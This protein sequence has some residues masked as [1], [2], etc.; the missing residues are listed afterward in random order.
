[1]GTAAEGHGAVDLGRG[2]EARVRALENLGVLDTGREERFDRLT[3]LARRL[4]GVASAAVT[5]IDRDRLYIKS[6]D[7]A[8]LLDGPR[9]EAF[10]DQTIR[11]PETLVV[12]DMRTD[13]R[14]ADNPLVTGDPHVRFYAGH[15]LTAPGGHRVGA[16]CLIDDRPRTFTPEER[17]LLEELADWAQQELTRSAELEQAA[18]V[19]R[20][21]LPRHPPRIAGYDVAGVCLPSRAVGGDFLDWY[22]TQDGGLAVTLGDVMGKGMG[23]ALVMAMVRTAMRSTGRLHAPADALREA[24]GALHEDLE[25]TSTLV[26]LC[27]AVLRPD[28][29]VVRYADAG[30]GLMLL[31]RADGS[32]H[33]DVRGDLPLGVLPGVD[34]HEAKV[35]LGPG[36]VVL[37]FSD[38]LLDLYPGTLLHALDEIATTIRAGGEAADVVDRF[39]DRAHRAA[40][41]DDDVTVLA[42]RRLP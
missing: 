28:D 13:A 29:D 38:G 12:E 10:C 17:V 23:A 15:P 16:L 6:S 11:R 33:R 37:A 4:F 8:Q 30:H 7:G 3:G 1:M 36:D 21:L 32:V 40:L 25:E 39:A 18:L 34:W 22:P 5:L 20:G 26:T 2:D 31:V 9:N 42:I 27:H 24:A 14:F 41:L 35:V 19:Q